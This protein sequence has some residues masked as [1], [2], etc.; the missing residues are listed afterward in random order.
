MGKPILDAREALMAQLF[1]DID[2]VVLRV[3]NVDAELASKVKEACTDAVN[4]AFLKAK[5]D[6]TAVIGENE[7]KLVDAGRHAAAQIGN[8]LNSGA[9][10]IIAATTMLEHK[11]RRLLVLLAGFTLGAGIIGGFVG[12]KLAHVM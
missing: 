2:R 8:Q 5:M 7:R 4:Q 12:A 1:E 3:E 6:L 11:T 10:Q 9:V